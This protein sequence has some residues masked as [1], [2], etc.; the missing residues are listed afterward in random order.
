MPRRN[1]DVYIEINVK[2]DEAMDRLEAMQDRMR[3]FGPVF[4]WAEKHLERIY[5]ENFTTMGLM[6]AQAM[7]RNAWPPLD[8][9]YGAWK[10]SR[11]PGAPTLVRTGELFKSV[12]DMSSGP[13]NKI[14]DHQ[15]EFGIA[16]RIAQYHQYGTSTMPARKIIFVPRN[17]DKDLGKKVEQYVV[18]G[19]ELT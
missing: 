6:A 17:F 16:G 5:S 1:A 8:A 15:A 11:F 3:D 19:S 18:K 4:K 2:A 7:L 14:S 13:I 12:A 9:E 10:S